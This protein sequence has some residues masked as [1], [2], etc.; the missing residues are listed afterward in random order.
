MSVL[1]RIAGLF[2]RGELAG[3][4]CFG[5]TNTGKVRD[6]NEDYFSLFPERGLYIVAD[7]MGGHRAGEVAS[8]ETVEALDVYFDEQ[9][10]AAIAGDPEKIKEALLDGVQTAHKTV[11]QMGRDNLHYAGMGCTVVVVLIDGDSLHVCHVGD[12][13]AYL[14]TEKRMIL[15]TMD[16]SYVMELVK[17][18]K[19]TMSEARTIAIK[20]ELTQAVGPAPVIYPDYIHK[21]MQPG[22]V[23]MLCSDGLWDMLPDAVIDET[24][25][26]AADIKQAGRVLVRLANHAGGKDN[27]TVALVR[28]GIDPPETAPEGEEE[29]T[30]AKPDPI[31][32]DTKPQDTL[33]LPPPVEF[34]GPNP[35]IQNKKE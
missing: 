11:G 16:H 18:G 9:R 7:G 15:L 6:H 17:A 20:N 5:K 4:Q 24:I 26:E 34:Q 29:N 27:I 2:T 13:R 35:E 31:D 1:K 12:S 33:P 10:M 3:E 30:E 28:Y 22:N 23:V 25:R 32:H 8:R 21:R 19:L 14:V